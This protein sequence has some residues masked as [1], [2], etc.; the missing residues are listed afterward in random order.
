MVQRAS[1]WKAAIHNGNYFRQ[2][3]AVKK[4]KD[5]SLPAMSVRR[6]TAVLRAR[7][8]RWNARSARVFGCDE[9]GLVQDN[10]IQF[11]HSIRSMW[12]ALIRARAYELFEEL[13]RY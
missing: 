13:G 11:I 2:R 7:S 4:L 10:P 3:R 5:V 1:Y 12:W 8:T 6:R 9:T